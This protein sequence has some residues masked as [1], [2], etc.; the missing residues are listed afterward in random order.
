MERGSYTLKPPFRKG[1]VPGFYPQAQ[2]CAEFRN[3]GP[4][5][6]VHYAQLSQERWAGWPNTPLCPGVVVGSLVRGNGPPCPLGLA[7]LHGFPPGG[8][9]RPGPPWPGT[10]GFH[11]KVRAWVV[12]LCFH[13]LRHSCGGAWGSVRRS[14]GNGEG[15]G[16][17]RPS[18][19]FGQMAPRPAPLFSTRGRAPSAG[20]TGNGAFQCFR[21]L[22][23]PDAHLGRKWPRPGLGRWVQV[24]G[25]E[26]CSGLRAST[27][28]S[29][30]LGGEHRAGL[31]CPWGLR[32]GGHG[33]FHGAPALPHMQPCGVNPPR[34]WTG[35][36]PRGLPEGMLQVPGLARLD[37]RLRLVGIPVVCGQDPASSPGPPAPSCAACWAAPLIPPAPHRFGM[38]VETAVDLRPRQA[39]LLLEPHQTLREVAGEDVGS[40]AVVCALS[41]HRAGPSNVCVGALSLRDRGA[42][43]A[44]C[45]LPENG[46]SPVRVGPPP[47]SDI[48]VCG[49]LALAGAPDAGDGAALRRGSRRSIAAS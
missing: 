47:A 11:S 33:P 35:L 31:L 49:L 21:V 2:R 20:F 9:F 28:A 43:A 14:W 30:P 40:S 19:G 10:M 15:L 1:I 42:S 27:S 25:P 7:A 36:R 44:A 46:R 3:S 6:G 29:P 12:G 13:S 48:H 4:I 5:A 34:R 17:A 8:V 16:L 32:A 22:G 39:R 38:G 24:R 26:G 41:R 18:A 45:P 23:A 37:R